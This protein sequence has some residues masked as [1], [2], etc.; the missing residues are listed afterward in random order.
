VK[1]AEA[2]ALFRENWGTGTLDGQMD[3][4]LHGN[5]D[6]ASSATGDFRWLVSGTWGGSWKGARPEHATRHRTQWTAA[7]TIGNE[8]LTLTKGP[9][10]GTIG[11]NRRLNLEWT[12][13]AP[14]ARVAEKRPA[15]VQ[16]GG[17]LAHPVESD[18]RRA[19][20]V[21]ASH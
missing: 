17:T 18:V 12:G 16:I 1:L 5:S 14:A 11:F 10:R 8:A 2:G 9:A 7:G 20:L 4:N 21:R 3:L 6:L 19:T 13:G 15:P